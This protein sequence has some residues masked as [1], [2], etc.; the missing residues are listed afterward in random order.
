MANPL[1]ALT[2]KNKPFA[3]NSECQRA[4]SEV[5]TST[6]VYP[7]LAMPTDEVKS[8]LDTGASDFAI[9]AVPSQIQGKMEER[10]I[11]FGS[12]AL[13]SVETNY[14]T[15]WKKLLAIVNFVKYYKHYLLGRNSC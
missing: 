11:A 1:T 3:W 14:S 13:S 12:R 8:I 2:K 9:G 6:D 10:D 15:T 5:K 4:F 7:I